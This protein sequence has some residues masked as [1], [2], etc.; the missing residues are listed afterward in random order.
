MLWWYVGTL[1]VS[2]SLLFLVQ[3]MFARMVLPLLGG[4]PAVWNTCMVFFQAALLAGYL[5]AHLSTRWLGARKQAATHLVLV[6]IPLLL[7][8]FAIDDSWVPPAERNPVL[9]LLLLLVTTLGLPFFVVS[10]SAPLLQRWFSRTSHRDAGDP[11][12]LYAASNL[13]SMAA[14]LAYPLLLEPLL[15]VEDQ[16][17]FWM[18]GYVALV[19]LLV[20]CAVFLWRSRRPAPPGSGVAT[21]PVDEIE[22]GESRWR[23]RARWLLLAAAPSSLMLGV[24]TFITTDLAVAPLLWVIPL[25]IYL[26]SFIIVFSRRPWLRH[27]WMVRVWPIAAIV[28][29]IVLLTRATQPVV[30][31]VAC[32]LLV[33]FLA[34]MICHGELARRRPPVARLTEFYLLMSLGGVLGGAFNALLAPLV[35]TGIVEYPLMLVIVCLLAPSVAGGAKQAASM[36]NGVVGLRWLDLLAPIGVGA[37][38]LILLAVVNRMDVPAGPLRSAIVVALPALACYLI[39][40]QSIRFALCVAVV[41]LTSSL[42]TA[43]RGDVL[44]AERSFFGVHRVT[45]AEVM[46]NELLGERRTYH[47]LYH[48]TTLHGA[49]HVDSDT[50]APA[51]PRR[52]LLYYHR[53]GPVGSFW[54]DLGPGVE[55]AGVIG[56]G[57]GMLAAYLDDGQ[58]LT[59]FEIDPI[60]QELAE[61]ARHFSFLSQARQRGATVDIVLGDARQ[62]LGAHDGPPFDLFVLDAFSSDAI[63][64]HLLT[65]EAMGLYLSR[66]A[67]EGALLLNI[68]NRYFDLK[69]LVAAIA[70]DLDLA[71]FIYDDTAVTE[72]MVKRLG[73]EGSIWAL[74]ARDDSHLD[75]LPVGRLGSGWHEHDPADRVEVWTDDYANLLSVFMW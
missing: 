47:R 14:L 58:H 70:D 16:S 36:L 18:V 42:D 57:A 53:E 59:Y 32:H 29:L 15:G 46:A 75:P 48:G 28:L 37:M 63:P 62:T 9:W 20:G 51:Q 25:A 13:G 10:A 26:A 4:S 45:R 43:H 38:A 23:Q 31:I 72:D 21:E 44:A 67:P 56:L 55:R 22:N 49:Q 17:R 52:P 5:Y 19:L 34:C 68:S 7:L 66:L 71:C 69:P 30:L 61:D 60:V 40:Q 24:T 74:L 39:S 11:Y 2:S 65:R 33:F 12:F 54:R 64:V 73:R 3:P 50:G 41:L 8:P 27:A 1:L 6:I 35:F